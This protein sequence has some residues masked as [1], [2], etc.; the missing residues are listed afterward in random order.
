MDSDVILN[1]QPGLVLPHDY[2]IRKAAILYRWEYRYCAGPVCSESDA[3]K[4]IAN[5]KADRY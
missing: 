2:P 4:T 3:P 1:S 5:E